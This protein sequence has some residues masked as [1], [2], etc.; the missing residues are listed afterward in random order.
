MLDNGGCFLGCMC[1]PPPA[2]RRR[3]GASASLAGV[4]APAYIIVGRLRP[5]A[6]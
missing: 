2:R 6:T 3:P 4:H 1:H 5:V